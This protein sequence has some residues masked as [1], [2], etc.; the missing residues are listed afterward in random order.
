MSEENGR[1]VVARNRKARHEF[2]VLDT[3]EAGLVLK[4]PEVKS[5]RAGHVAFRDAFARIE[6]AEVWLYS[7]HIAPYEQANRANVDPDRPRKLLLNRTEIRRLV[8]KVDGKGLT[9]VPLDIY[10]R[11]GK[12]KVTLAVARGRRLFDKREKL[13]QQSQ[14]RDAQRAM[15]KH[16]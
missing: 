8:G 1:K 11:R 16:G 7:L 12:A 14:E 9:L 2:E 4:G 6:R 13:K 5:L 15:D 3:Y 10:F